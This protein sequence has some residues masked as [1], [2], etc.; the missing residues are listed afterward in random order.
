MKSQESAK[1]LF[2]SGNAAEMPTAE[3]T[4]E[5]LENGTIGIT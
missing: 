2:S 3:L 5:D 1:A 4:D